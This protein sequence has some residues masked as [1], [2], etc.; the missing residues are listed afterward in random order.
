MDTREERPTRREE[1][2]ERGDGCA[3]RAGELAGGCEEER[4]GDAA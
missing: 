1:D 2:D 3:G 4:P